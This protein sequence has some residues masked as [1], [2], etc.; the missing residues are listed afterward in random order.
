MGA[1]KQE[2]LNRLQTQDAEANLTCKSS[3]LVPRWHLGSFCVTPVSLKEY[4][5]PRLRK[6]SRPLAGRFHARLTGG[7]RTRGECMP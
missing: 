2:K 7:M 1:G 6:Q 5:T 3:L 4:L